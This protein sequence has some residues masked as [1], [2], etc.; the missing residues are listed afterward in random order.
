MPAASDSISSGSQRRHRVRPA[1]P[2]VRYGTRWT[3]QARVTRSW[4]RKSTRSPARAASAASSS[5]ASIDQSSRGQPAGSA[6]AASRRCD[7]VDADPAGRGAAGV[8]HDQHPPVALGPPGAHHHVGAAGGGPPVDR[9][10][11]VADH[12]LAQ[13][14][15]LG[16]LAADQ[17]RRAAVE[18]AQPGQPRRQVLAATGTAAAPGPPRHPVRALPAGEAQR[19]DRPDRHQCRLPVA[20]ADRGQR[21]VEPAALARR[22]RPPRWMRGAAPR[23]TAARR[24][25]ARRGT[26]ARPR[27]STDQLDR[28]RSRRAAPPVVRRGSAKR[29]AR[30]LPASARSTRPPPAPAGAS[31][32][33]ER[34]RGPG[35]QHDRERAEQREQPGAS[36]QQPLSAG[37]GTEARM[38]S[39]TPSA[40]AP[41]SSASGRSCDPVPQRRPGQRLDVVGGDVVA[42][43]QPRP[44]PRR[45]QQRGRAARGH[46]ELQRRGLP[47]GADDVHDVAEHLVARRAPAGPRPGRRPGRRRPATGLHRGQVARVEAV[48]VPFEDRDLLVARRQRH[49]QL[50]QEPVELRLGQLVGALVLDRV[51][52]RGDDERVGQRRGRRRRR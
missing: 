50:E 48:R 25:G 12:V 5:A 39:S 41:S 19:P 14:V 22:R 20:A 32:H 23:A 1:R 46:A 36:G 9:A 52:G 17:R 28:R 26:G 27:F 42:A 16:A 45:G 43:R 4:A 15:E 10:H 24:P 40:V 7:G 13:R 33:D 34:R 30:T 44:G 18:L 35:E 8:E 21:H 49:G 47:G 11:V 51:L 6:I 38:P 2:A 3:T 31:Q 37:T 29:S